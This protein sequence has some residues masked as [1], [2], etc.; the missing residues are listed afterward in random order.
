MDKLKTRILLIS[1]LLLLLFSVQSVAAVSDDDGNLTSESIDLSICD[2]TG[3]VSSDELSNNRDDVLSAS[4]E[5]DVLSADEATYSTLYGEITNGG[6]IVELQHDYYI[7]DGYSYN[8][9]ISGDNRII[10]GKGAVIDMAGSNI[11]A[12][13]ISGSG[14]IIKNLTI[15]NTDTKVGGA[16]I[17]FSGSGTVEN[18]NFT[19]NS[20]SNSGGAVYFWNNGAV[21]NC[22][23]ANNKAETGGAFYSDGTCTVTN[24]NFTNNSAK[25]DGNAIRCTKECN[26]TNCNFINNTAFGSSVEGT[27]CINSG[28]DQVKLI[29]D[30]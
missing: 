25:Y 19:N 10:D 22:S 14:T 23:F 13:S 30:H 3:D 1:L 27:I 6:D 12:F 21:T 2:N 9:V 4:N 11:Q 5:L 7:Y 16:A 26:V 28:S 15:M 29:L 8:I 17:F 20:A 18:C 24:C